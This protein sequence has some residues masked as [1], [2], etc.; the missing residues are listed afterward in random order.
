M[1]II[2]SKNSSL[3]AITCL[4]CKNVSLTDTKKLE[5]VPISYG[6]MITIINIQNP[7][8]EP[9]NTTNG[10]K[11]TAIPTSSTNGPTVISVKP[12]ETSHEYNVTFD[13]GPT[14]RVEYFT[15]NSFNI[16]SMKPCTTY[17]FTVTTTVNGTS[18]LVGME[19]VT[20]ENLSMLS[21]SIIR[22]DCLQHGNHNC[23][24]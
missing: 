15:G 11:T 2:C 16:M 3:Y 23:I 14:K 12:D 13:D 8:S 6:V 22:T 4:K 9:E 18:C 17:S 10:T 5:I 24:I 1:T 20:T 19:T 7:T 21:Y